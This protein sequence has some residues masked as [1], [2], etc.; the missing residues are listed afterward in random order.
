MIGFLLLRMSI[1]CFIRVENLFVDFFWEFNFF[2]ERSID[3]EFK[4]SEN[5]VGAIE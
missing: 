1:D 4:V 3:D 5:V 2:E